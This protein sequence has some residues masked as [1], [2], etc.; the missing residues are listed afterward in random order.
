MSLIEH[1]RRGGL[2]FRQSTNPSHSIFIMIFGL[3]SRL[4]S[5]CER[6]SWAF[7]RTNTGVD[8]NRLRSVAVFG[9][10]VFLWRLDGYR[11][12][13]KRILNTQR[14]PMEKGAGFHEGKWLNAI[15]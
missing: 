15:S 11:F 10:G 12:L 1:G 8:V 2:L 4:R 6:S 7:E 14:L 9:G 3:G 5:H 13:L